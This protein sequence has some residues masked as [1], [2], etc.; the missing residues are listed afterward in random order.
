MAPPTKAIGTDVTAKGQNLET[1]HALPV[2]VGEAAR[3]RAASLEPDGQV[4]NLSVLER[5]LN[6]LLQPEKPVPWVHADG[7]GT[8]GQAV[9]AEVPAVVGLRL[10]CDV[11]RRPRR[12]PA[13]SRPRERHLRPLTGAPLSMACTR[14]LIRPDA[15]RST[16]RL[17]SPSEACWA[18]GWAAISRRHT[19]GAQ[20][21]ADMRMP[22]RQ[23]GLRHG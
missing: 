6:G 23:Q 4:E 3:D 19:T 1:R 5:H 16:A 22:P 20:M 9:E 8:A 10:A 14:P 15:A 11:R 2:A 21:R 7:V 17:S 13:A 12:R 18:D